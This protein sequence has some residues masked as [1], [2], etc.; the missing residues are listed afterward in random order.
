MLSKIKLVI[1]AMAIFVMSCVTVQDTTSLALN[2]KTDKGNLSCKVG[3]V[4]DADDVQADTVC[5]GVF[6]GSDG[7]TYLCKNVSLEYAKSGNILKTEQDCEIVVS[8]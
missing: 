1:I 8:K 6:T 4:I 5:S 7:N 3:L 2:V